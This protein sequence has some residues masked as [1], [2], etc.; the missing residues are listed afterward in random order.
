[1][2][3]TWIVKGR[4]EWTMKPKTV[5]VKANSKTEAIEKGLKKIDTKVFYE[6]R[7]ISA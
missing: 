3:A 7:L 5:K 2:M 6:C 1:M 4:D